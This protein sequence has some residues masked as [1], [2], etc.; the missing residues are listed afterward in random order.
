MRLARNDINGDIYFQHG[1][2]VV[3]NRTPSEASDGIDS[4]E[5]QLREE[6][7][8]DSVPWNTLPS[9]RRGVQALK[10]HLADL[11]YKKMQEA[12][13]K[14]LADIQDRI[15]L[16]STALASLGSDRASIEQKR[17]YLTRI[18]HRFN[19]IA[20]DV[21]RGRYD[22]IEGDKMKLR[23]HVRDANDGFMRQLKLSGHRLPFVAIPELEY[24]EGPG[25]IGA[26]G[27]SQPTG[28]SLFPMPQT[29]GQAAG[30]IGGPSFG[31]SEPIKVGAENPGT[32][33]ATFK[34]YI[35]Q[36]G[37]ISPVMAHYQ[38]ISF[39]PWLA[40][41]SFEELRL[42][43]YVQVQSTS[44][45]SGNIFG[46]PWNPAP[47]TSKPAVTTD[48]NGGLATGF[49][50]YASNNNAASSPFGQ[51]S[52]DSKPNTG[53]SGGSIFAN[54]GTGFGSATN[55]LP[56][57]S[58]FGS[59]PNDKPAGGL[60]G[61]T[62]DNKSTTNIFKSS[63]ND[64][65]AAGLFGST[66]D[67]KSTTNIFGSSQTDKPA[68][69]LFAL[70]PDRKPS[71]SLFGPTPGQ[72]PTS[73]P[74]KPANGPTPGSED[75]DPQNAEIYRWIRNEIKSNRGTEL[76]GTLNAD[77]LPM[78]F[79]QQACKW[80]DIAEKH[81]ATVVKF[82]LSVLNGI[83]DSVECDKITKKKIRPLIY[84]ASDAR[85]DENTA[86][87]LE[88]FNNIRSRHL[89][90]SNTSFEQKVAQARYKRFQ[91]ALDRY[92]VLQQQKNLFAPNN[93]DPNL[94]FVVDMRDTAQLFSELHMSNSRNLENEIHDTLKAYYEIAR[95]DYI[96][97]V[98]QHIVENF[99]NS[100]NGPVLMFSPLYV[101]G[102]SDGQIQELAMEDEGVVK[103]RV[104]KEAT[105]KRLKSAERIALRYA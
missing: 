14:M 81:F 88:R 47:T 87:L 22:L 72:K 35:E 5:R 105:L 74:M 29:N 77:I 96:E 10:K 3:R 65:P 83:L 11:L 54:L 34:P 43:D 56:T 9:S 41:F 73:P 92:R 45:N 67:N 26:Q 44:N 50:Q 42:K 61:S 98:T 20:L 4:A 63:P 82:S 57:T 8:F 58:A 46:A 62:P 55:N 39:M 102:L 89:Q 59:S 104:E 12:F 49:A 97:Y 52:K 68:A 48:A 53:G 93:T 103:D 6:K 13:P 69:G 23:K 78:L 27:T 19:T 2:F 79:H 100:D 31:K 16:T 101:A 18:A 86:S 95:D 75:T 32:R 30:G 84:D 91:A 64:K 25:G 71:P 99:I 85:E 37:T 94:Q 80:G 51:A 76:Q 33:G 21:L 70:P 60:F 36:E 24:L 90:T 15:K 1:W 66:P 7:L 28:S 40:K 38:S 17:T